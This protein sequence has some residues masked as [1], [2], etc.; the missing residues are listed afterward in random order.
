MA[1]VGNWPGRSLGNGRAAVVPVLTKATGNDGR[2]QHHE[3]HQRND[4][5][6]DETDKVFRVLEQVCIPASYFG[7][8]CA[9]IAQ[10]PWILCIS[11]ANDD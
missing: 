1:G 6:R 2:A 5:D 4:H 10:Y 7:R 9:Q 3:R 11:F 8:V